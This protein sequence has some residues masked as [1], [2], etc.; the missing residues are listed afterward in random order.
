M[1]TER[2]IQRV[3]EKEIRKYVELKEKRQKTERRKYEKQN[4]RK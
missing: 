1:N 3:R 4:E 2:Q